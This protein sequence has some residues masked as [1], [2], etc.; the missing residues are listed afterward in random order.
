MAI[1]NPINNTTAEVVNHMTVFRYSFGSSSSSR[2]ERTSATICSRTAT[3]RVPAATI[4]RAV[5]SPEASNPQN[6]KN[7]NEKPNR[8]VIAVM[9]PNSDGEVSTSDDWKEFRVA[10][11]DIEELTGLDFLADVPQSVQDAVET[12]VDDL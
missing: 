3:T 10:P 11:R 1:N 12:Q 9:I 5:H 2:R 8:T 6:R 4:D 7:A